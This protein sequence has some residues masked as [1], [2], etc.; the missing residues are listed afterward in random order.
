M[1]RSSFLIVNPNVCLFTVPSCFLPGYLLNQIVTVCFYTVLH[2]RNSCKLKSCFYVKI[3]SAIDYYKCKSSSTDIHKA[4]S[5]N[6]LEYTFKSNHSLLHRSIKAFQ[7]YY[8]QKS[9]HPW[10]LCV[11]PSFLFTVFLFECF[12]DFLP[13]RSQTIKTEEKTSTCKRQKR[14][15]AA[16]AHNKAWKLEE[17]SQRDDRIQLCVRGATKRR[18]SL[19]HI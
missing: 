7:V 10:A 8:N 17:G 3:F 18:T 9:T 16:R 11:V 13:L 2:F 14:K 5:V 15:R 19:P 4:F 6:I 12:I 1:A